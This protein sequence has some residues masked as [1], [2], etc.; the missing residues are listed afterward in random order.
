METSDTEVRDNL[1]SGENTGVNVYGDG[2]VLQGNKVGTDVTGTSALEN[3]VG[4]NVIGADDNLI[5][6][7]ADGEGNLMSGNDASGVQLRVEATT[8]R[9]S[10]MRSRAT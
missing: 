4:V 10:A 2:N 3:F 8:I 1:V 9:P 6:G 5:G 7:T